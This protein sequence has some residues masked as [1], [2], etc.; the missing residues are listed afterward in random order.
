MSSSCCNKFIWITIQVQPICKELL[1]RES[2]DELTSY[3]IRLQI[4]QDKKLS[5]RREAARCFTTLNISQSHSRSLKM[6]PFE[7]LGMVSYLHSIVTMSVTCIVS[8]TK[9]DIGRK[10]QFFRITLAF[11]TLLRGS[12]SE[13]CHTIWCRKT[14]MAWLPEGEKVWRYV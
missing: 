11:N 5:C 13:Y 8:E 9:P 4:Q 10:L 3:V 12:P 6:V 14:R 7:S 2:K 1:G